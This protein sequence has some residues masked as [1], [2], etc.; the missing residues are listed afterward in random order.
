[1]TRRRLPIGVQNFRE[2]REGNCYYVDKTGF[3]GQLLK[4]GKHY[5][6]SRPRRFGKSL[7][8]DTCKELFEAN[9]PLFDG[10][11]IHGAW[12]WSVRHPVLRLSFG[13]GHFSA[14]DDLRTEVVDRLKTMEDHAGIQARH[15]SAPARLRHLIET[16]HERTGCRVAVL[17]DEYDKPIL[18]AL[19]VP[20]VARANRDYLRGLYAVVKDCDAHIRFS[21]ITGVSKF[22]KVS[23]FSGLNNLVDITM[24]ARYSA[25]CGYTD[26]DL[27]AVFSPE[28]SAFDRD[29][30][31]DWYNGYCWRGD[32]KVYNP[33]DILLL[34]DN[35]EFGAWWFETGTPA[36]LV[37]T[38]VERQV[39][40][41]AVED[42]AG[43]DNLLSRF[44]VDDMGTE[45]L[46]FQTGYLTIRDEEVIG[47]KNLY[48]LGYPNREVRQSFNEHLL[49]YLVNDAS[50][51]TANS[52]QLYRL[53]EA[54]DFDGLGA[55]FQAFF[56]SIPYEWYTNNDIARYEG[57]YASV[58]Y[59]YF[60]AL[61]L[62][63]AVE[64]STSHGRLDMA[65]RFRGHV[66]L[67][68]F[69][70]V[71]MASEGAAMAQLQE[72]RYADKYRDSG[73]PIHLIGV[74]FSRDSRNIVA[75][76]VERV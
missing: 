27:D 16:L 19:D 39:S 4:Q 68:E 29:K 42:M 22:S 56:A 46:L 6:L 37:E 70:V 12:D 2:I 59:A 47:G 62:D 9:E 69:K 51:Q 60:A 38:L 23:L 63:I 61:G 18:D 53:L 75:F 26:A 48:R 71:E 57:Y 36:F 32:A 50:R 67:F 1:M 54:N 34:F 72:R 74:E 31:R 44:D 58:F 35:G 43:T 13:S 17:V 40:A 30:V 76:D 73:E 33:F 20:E 66:Y 5:F 25:I 21:F 49:R 24:D 7:F 55:V 14:P 8:L 65:V 64:D 45:A 15:T 52:V 3:I 41:V 11:A 28:V 10:L